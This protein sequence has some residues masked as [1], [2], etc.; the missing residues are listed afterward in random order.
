MTDTTSHGIYEEIDINVFIQFVL[1]NKKY[2]IFFTSLGFLI[3]III[4]S[5]QKNIYRGELQIL[6]DNKKNEIS[7]MSL[8]A[9]NPNINFLLGNKGSDLNT[10]KELLKSPSVL[11]PIFEFV[12]GEKKLKDNE[13]SFLSWRDK[14]LKVKFIKGTS[15]LQINYLDSE[16]NLILP[17]LKKISSTYQNYPDRNRIKGLKNGILY[18]DN[19]ISKYKKKSQKSIKNLQDF[20]YQNDLPYSLSENSKQQN[21][22]LLR[23][24]ATNK[25]REIDKKLI[26]LEKVSNS[27]QL[28]R[29]LAM[30]KSTSLLEKENINIDP[31]KDIE[32]KII[33]AQA[34]YTEQDP[35]IKNLKKNRELFLKA[36]KD[37]TISFLKIKKS[38]ALALK[39]STTR[40]KEIINKYRLLS[41]EAIRDQSILERLMN[42]KS[43]ISLSIAKQEKPWELVS[44]PKLYGMPI[45]RD[46]LKNAIIGIL[47]FSISSIFYFIVKENI[48][49]LIYDS[50]RIN[51]DP[52]FKKKIL[53]ES[54]LDE[55]TFSKIELLLSS[56]VDDIESS[57]GIINLSSDTNIIK[58]ID[59]YLKEM[60]YKN[61]TTSNSVNK[62]FKTKYKIII[63]KIRENTYKDLES[64]KE[65]LLI[66]SKKIDSIILYNGK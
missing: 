46:Y 34:K 13:L 66:N 65:Q 63:A 45:E 38:N 41:I 4:T 30:F 61:Y 56:I 51:N 18:L 27:N 6:L 25:I 36:L 42:S 49:D 26:E 53:I 3:G 19:Q 59:K 37:E 1:R 40:P 23:I 10:E 64:V 22:E 55:I 43:E 16:K 33:V 48:S 14:S 5:L 20:A 8:F 57:I 62:I 50:S 52:I 12:K 28:K 2:L 15:I 58:K 60:N 47:L 35:F 44:Q 39:K 21:I 9:N 32:D 7:N 31:L 17:V 24:S 11:M 54:D 29:Y